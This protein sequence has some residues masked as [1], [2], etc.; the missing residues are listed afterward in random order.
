MTLVGLGQQTYLK[1][2]NIMADINQEL[3]L[4]SAIIDYSVTAGKPISYLY[5]RMVT[6][7]NHRSIGLFVDSMLRQHA[8]L[9]HEIRIYGPHRN[10]I[11]T[12]KG[13]AA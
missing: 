3:D 7:R 8:K 13:G 1:R 10:L 6:R 9:I 5:P 4:Y 12:I 11:N 2:G